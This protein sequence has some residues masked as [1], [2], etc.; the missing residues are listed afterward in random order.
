MTL[1]SLDGQIGPADEA[2][3]PRHRRGAAARRRRVRGHAPLRR[4]AVRARA[5]TSTAC[6]APAT[7][8]RL[9]ADHD[10]LARRARRAAR[11]GR[12][13]RRP[14]AGRGDARRAADR[15]RRAAAARARRSRA[16]PRS[17]SRPDRILDGLKTLSYAGN[18]LAGR[19]AKERGF[20]EALLVTPHGRVLEGPTWTFFWVAGRR[21]V[22]AAARGPHPRLDHPRAA[23]R[24]VRRLRALVHARRRPRGRGGVH[25][26]DRAR[27]DADRRGRRH[28]A[29]GR[30]RAGDLDAHARF[31][32]RVE[33]ELAAAPA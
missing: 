5:T 27:G 10:A 24:G 32:R 31:Q 17:P 2:A 30:A 8:L 25:R 29:A 15:D 21:A 16:W 14:A 33:R 23:A 3:H 11:G 19:L 13:G 6:G 20:D 1:A 12:P 26:L 28:R 4:A 9:E 22:H 18:M 7:G